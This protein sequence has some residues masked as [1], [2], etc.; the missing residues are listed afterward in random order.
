MLTVIQ[1]YES[2]AAESA[3]DALG[4]V[5]ATSAAA[6]AAGTAASVSEGGQRAPPPPPPPMQ[7]SAPGAPPAHLD[8]ALARQQSVRQV[9]L[10]PVASQPSVFTQLP[11]PP[12]EDEDE[13]IRYVDNLR[14][15][16]GLLGTP[17][18]ASGEF[19]GTPEATWFR[20][21]S[22]LSGRGED[23]FVPLGAAQGSGR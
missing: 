13:G 8:Q 19:V 21:R 2:V 4:P 18:K 15:V 16:G 12:D 17:L 14:V 3:G 5:A 11:A 22:S 1:N 9:H 20:Q 10:P 7:M 23:R 6:V